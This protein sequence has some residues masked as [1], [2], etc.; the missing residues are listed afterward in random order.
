MN[1]ERTRSRY[2]PPES[3]D[4][5]KTHPSLVDS[6]EEASKSPAFREALKKDDE[7]E[8]RSDFAPD[9]DLWGRSGAGPDVAK[10]TPESSQKTE[11]K[12][13]DREEGYGD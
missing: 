7:R 12:R 5:P 13:A 11:E 10:K 6:K 3:G 2:V 1:D 9:K 4:S 8:A